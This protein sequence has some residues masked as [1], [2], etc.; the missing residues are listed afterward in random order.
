MLQL[1]VEDRVRLLDTL[2]ASHS[3]GGR[4]PC[5]AL[6][7]RNAFSLQVLPFPCAGLPHLG[8]FIPSCEA[9][10]TQLVSVGWE[11]CQSPRFSTWKP[12]CS[13]PPVQPRAGTNGSG[14]SMRAEEGNRLLMD[15][16]A[17]PV[18]RAPRK[19][20]ATM[21]VLPEGEP[22]VM[23]RKSSPG[24]RAG[25]LSVKEVVAQQAA[26]QSNHAFGDHPSLLRGPGAHSGRC[27][28]KLWNLGF[29]YAD[30]CLM[31][32]FS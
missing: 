4:F 1:L 6:G 8:A 29:M 24:S 9:K 19:Q 3:S 11:I 2:S 17:P 16:Q 23:A 15:S 18:V 13:S 12:P 14:R 5:P 27:C 26:Q 32:F 21:K 31:L 30:F 20:T 22:E 25:T 7:F 28:F 10:R